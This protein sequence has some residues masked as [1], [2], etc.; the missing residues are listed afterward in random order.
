MR[1]C[2]LWL[3]GNIYAF[4]RP[5]SISHTSRTVIRSL[6]SSLYS[7]YI[8]F[9]Y[10]NC[11][12][13]VCFFNQILAFSCLNV[14]LPRYHGW[15]TIS[16]YRIIGGAR[17]SSVAS[18]RAKLDL[19]GIP[20]SVAG[21]Y[22]DSVFRQNVENFGDI[23]YCTLDIAFC[24]CEVSCFLHRCCLM[25]VTVGSPGRELG[26]HLTVLLNFSFEILTNPLKKREY[27]L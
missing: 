4:H 21:Y 20:S 22:I 23:V 1:L 17:R 6:W 12:I 19:D 2:F 25:T 15:S 3:I 26:G 5:G 11:W 13:C 27:T 18:V 10:D 8:S 24:L 9:P 14:Y 16:D 7:L